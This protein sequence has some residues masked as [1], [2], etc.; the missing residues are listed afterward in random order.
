MTLNNDAVT[1]IPEVQVQQRYFTT[2][3]VIDSSERFRCRT[4]FDSGV[5]L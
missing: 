2:T 3:G 1:Y 5:E 4:Y